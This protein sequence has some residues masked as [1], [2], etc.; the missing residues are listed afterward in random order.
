MRWGNPKHLHESS[1]RHYIKIPLKQKT[2]F[3]CF[4]LYVFSC[5]IMRVPK[6]QHKYR[7]FC[8][9]LLIY[10]VTW[11]KNETNCDELTRVSSKC[12]ECFKIKLNIISILFL[13]KI[14]YMKFKL[15]LRNLNYVCF[16]NVF[17][18]SSPFLWV[19]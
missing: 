12:I 7:I 13:Y 10:H 16:S 17:T 18:F 6:L 15:C 4:D 1:F 5:K 8:Q 2:C 19:W 11:W 3:H 14:V 9:M